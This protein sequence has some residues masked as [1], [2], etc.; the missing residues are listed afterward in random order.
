[1]KTGTVHKI[2]D[3]RYTTR[4]LSLFAGMAPADHPRLVLVVVIDDPR[5]G[6]HYGGQVAAPAF[7]AIMS[8]ALRLL[9]VTPDVVPTVNMA[10]VAADRARKP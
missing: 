5:A 9:N 8:G 10:S 6:H 7:S 4:Y 1:G 3:G 2:V